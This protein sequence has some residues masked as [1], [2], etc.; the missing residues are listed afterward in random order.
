MVK[1]NLTKTAVLQLEKLAE[2]KPIEKYLEEKVLMM[3]VNEI[4]A[5]DVERTQKAI[6]QAQND[7]N[8]KREEVMDELLENPKKEGGDKK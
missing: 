8:K 5:G 2:N 6:K 4:T 1:L 7:L 3:L